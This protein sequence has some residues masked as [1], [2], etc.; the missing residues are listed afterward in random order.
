M[1]TRPIEAPPAQGWIDDPEAPGLFWLLLPDGRI[2]VARVEIPGRGNEWWCAHL[3]SGEQMNA[4]DCP[5]GARWYHLAPP[6]ASIC[7]A[8]Q[9]APAPCRTTHHKGC[10]CWEAQ[11][12]AE[13]T[14]AV[15]A[16]RAAC[17]QRAD[18]ARQAED[19]LRALTPSR[20]A[21]HAHGADVAAAI[22]DAIRAR[23]GG[24]P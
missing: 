24:A 4:R 19:R 5:D 1:E 12:D 8:R 21:E 23:G 6:T 16:E 14:A 13:I 20:E 11:R 15:A 18:R 17:A 10:A 9:H 7:S 22:R 2:D 3:L